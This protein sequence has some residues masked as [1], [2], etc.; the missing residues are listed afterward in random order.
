MTKESLNRHRNTF[1]WCG[2]VLRVGFRFV[3]QRVI[4]HVIGHLKLHRFDRSQKV[5]E[6]T[7]THTHNR[8]TALRLG[9][10]G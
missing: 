8:L 7:R 2:L 9:L 3:V 4:Q 5:K 6:H 1:W 10:P